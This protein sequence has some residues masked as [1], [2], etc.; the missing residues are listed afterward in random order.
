AP[1]G[2]TSHQVRDH[3]QSWVSE[4]LEARLSPDATDSEDYINWLHA[5]STPRYVYCLFADDICLESMDHPDF[6]SPVVKILDKN[7]GPLSLEE[8]NY[9]VHAPYHDG[10]SE[11]SEEDVGWM[12]LPLQHY[13]WKYDWLAKSDWETA[14]VRPPYIDGSETESDF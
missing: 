1:S 8:R 3:F 11:D 13:L 12:Y 6:N 4:N 5:T 2:A 7:W 10:A 14:Y 9:T